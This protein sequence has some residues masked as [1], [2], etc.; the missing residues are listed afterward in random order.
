MKSLKI[1]LLYICIPLV[2]VAQEKH[3]YFVVD[4]SGSMSGVPL[5]EAKNAMQ[6]MGKQF[7]NNGHKIALVVGEDSCGQGTRVSTKFFSLMTELNSALKLI[8][9]NGSHNI[10]LGFEH[11]QNEMKKNAYQGH[12]Y[13]F[14]DCDGLEHCN[15]ITSISE[16][17]KKMNALTP[18]TY[19]EVDGC[20]NQE[21]KAW[22]SA[23]KKVGA[24]KGLAK[25]FSYKTITK[26]KI[27]P[28][29]KYFTKFKY[30]NTDGSSNL[31]TNFSDKPW[32]CI[33]SDGLLWL[34]INKEEQEL[35]FYI[36]K[37][38][39]VTMDKVNHNILTADFIKNLN[40]HNT[41]AKNDW[42][43]PDNFELSRLTQLGPDLR[44]E[45]FP[46]I[47]IWAHI[48]STG[49]KF[50]NFKKGVDLN[51]GKSY[52]YREDRPYASIFVSG[53]IDKALFVAP[54]EIL[55]RLSIITGN[56]I[57]NPLK[58]TGSM[59]AYGKC[60]H[61]ECV[62]Q[63]NCTQSPKTQALTKK[64]LPDKC[65]GSMVS[66]GKCTQEECIALGQCN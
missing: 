17:Y 45:I 20:T 2:L 60:T 38:N 58:C 47:K 35:N 53:D 41:C 50:N 3:I 55:N 22:G 51:N 61:E 5:Q 33:E 56:P 13:I 66:D 37:P 44:T 40:T 52:D 14:G 29:K 57:K 59:A 10:T 64:P 46:Y 24:K 32:R 34:A 7:F 63:G 18:F 36:K 11:A 25:T 4:G 31:G 1:A 43:L 54:D 42:R 27:N 48:S 62:L 8:K 16:K 39:N 26:K 19:L 65:T 12:I 21:K 49:G 15:S 30:I 6:K 28:N 23:L 9:T